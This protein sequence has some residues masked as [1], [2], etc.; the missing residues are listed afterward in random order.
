MYVEEVVEEINKIRNNIKECQKICA[1][2][3]NT[4]LNRKII[5]T[6]SILSESVIYQ[7]QVDYR[8][9]TY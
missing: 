4:E 5:E 8:I 7:L 3:E 2:K 1:E 6:L 9:D